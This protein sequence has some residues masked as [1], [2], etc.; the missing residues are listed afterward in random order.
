MQRIR[1]QRQIRRQVK[2]LLLC[3]ALGIG[4]T[5]R[6]VIILAKGLHARGHQL[7]V[8]VFYADGQLEKE[9]RACGIAVIDLNKAGRWDALPFYVRLA[10]LVR[11]QRPEIVYGFLGTPNI[12]TTLLKPICPGMKIVWGVRASNVDLDRYDWLSRLIYR[13]ECHL[14]RFADLIISNSHAGLEYATAY[15]FPSRKMITIPNGIDVE[16]FKP[17]GTERVLIREEWNVAAGEILI[18]LI[19]RLDPMKDHPTFLRAAA[20]LRQEMAHVRFVCVGDGPSSYKAQLFRLATELGL[21]ENIIWTGER[22][23]MRAV[24]NALDIS[25]SSSCT[26]GFSNTIAEAMACGVPC[27]VTNVGDSALIVGETGEIVPP[28]V[29]DAFCE[30]IRLML[31]RLNPDLKNATRV[32]IANRFPKDALVTDTLNALQRVNQ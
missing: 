7:A 21:N 13:A 28:G 14:S 9:L 15:G 1:I 30:G 32:S 18:G 26:E 4:G 3:R 25:V 8:A 5:E 22:S 27:V 12:L 23:D 24:F 29:P 20:T 16:Y 2:I 10:R 31:K 19:G 17:N 6:Q 11:K